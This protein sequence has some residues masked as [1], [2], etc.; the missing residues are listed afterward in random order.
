[1]KAL[2]FSHGVTTVEDIGMITRVSDK[3]LIIE[4]A[5]QWP[6]YF[7][8]LFPV[9]VRSCIRSNRVHALRFR[10]QRTVLAK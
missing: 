10:C 7:C 3:K 4:Q 2:L 6:I 1:M 9:N 8:R 5:R